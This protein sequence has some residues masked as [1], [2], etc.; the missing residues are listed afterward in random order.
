[1]PSPPTPKDGASMEVLVS[2]T[3]TRMLIDTGTG[4]VK[5][6]MSSGPLYYDYSEPFEHILEIFP[7]PEGNEVL[8]EVLTGITNHAKKLLPYGPVAN[9]PR[10]GRVKLSAEV[11][12]AILPDIAELPASPVPRRITRDLILEGLEPSST[13]EDV[14]ESNKSPYSGKDPESGHSDSLPG[15]T[16]S[17]N[18]ELAAASLNPE[19]RNNQRH[20][21]LSQTGSSVLDSSTLNFAVRYSIPM[22]TTA[23]FGTDLARETASPASLGRSTEDGMSELLAGYQHT[24]SKQEPD[25]LQQVEGTVNKETEFEGYHEK[26]S[27]HT[28]RSSDERSFKSCTVRANPV[29]EPTSPK[30]DQDA[31]SF[32]SATD[33]LPEQEPS[34]KASNA[35]SINSQTAASPDRAASMPLSRPPS[36]KLVK[37][38]PNLVRT[39]S[40]MP[41]SSPPPAVLRKQPPSS[42]RESSLSAV[43]SKM[44]GSSRPSMA[45]G[46][47]SISGSS[48]NLGVMQ[49]PPVPPR[50]SSSSKEA[51]RF[52]GVAS[53]LAGMPARFTKGRKSTKDAR[54]AKLDAG[55]QSMSELTHDTSEFSSV[56]SSSQFPTEVIKVPEKVMSK[57][58]LVHEEQ[59]V[60]SISSKDFGVS[61]VGSV[62]VPPLSNRHDPSSPAPVANEPSSVY[63]PQD[64]SMQDRGQT[65]PIRV[66]TSPDR[67]RRDSQ[68]TTHLVWPGARR[69]L[70]MPSASASEPRL[71]LPSVQEDTTTDLRLSAYRYPGPSRYLPDLKEESHE[72]SSLNTSASNLKN[73]HFRFPHGGPPGVRTSVEDA[74]RLSRSSSTGSPRRSVRSSALGQTHGLPSMRFSKMNL[75]EKLNEELGLRYPRSV[76]IE[77]QVFQGG[78]APPPGLKSEAREKYRSLFAELDDEL[79]KVEGSAEP[80]AMLDLNT[81]KRAYSPEKLM[82]EI[83][84]LSIPSVGGLTQRISELVPSLKEYYKLGEQGEFVEE[85]LIM[86]HAMEDIH[87]VGGPAQKRSSA[88]LRP[89]AGSPNM[90]VIDD[91]L[92]EE[93]TNPD[94]GTASSGRQGDGGVECGHSE[95]GSH[96]KGK[97]EN[98]AQAQVLLQAPLTEI[99]TPPPAFLRPRSH[100][101]GQQQIRSSVESGL[102]SSRSLRSFTPTATDTRPWNSDR[103]YPWATTTIP[104]IDI[105]LP[106]PTAVKDSPR[107]GPSHLRNRLSNTS[108]STS[109]STADTAT[110]SPFGTA[111]GSNAHARQH[112]FS[113]FGRTGDQPHAAGERYPT[114]ALT[115]PTAIFRDHSSSLDTCDDEDFTVAPKSRLGLKKRFSSARSAALDNSTR[116]GRSKSNPLELASPESTKQSTTSKP[117]D[118]TGEA[119]VITANHRH[120]FRDAGGMPIST[121]HRSKIINHLKK[122]WHKGGELIRK[123]SGRKQEDTSTK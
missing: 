11:Q 28:G 72:D 40:E 64:F 10:P 89:M 111:S 73:S 53:F 61:K 4:V 62:G 2:P 122:W 81:L 123:I 59:I 8:N 16:N 102:S 32:K 94:K 52:Q 105:S 74:V 86:E 77:L 98:V 118:R 13:E 76:E 48:S 83:D 63:S 27:H 91:A 78:G 57:P 36:A 19:E 38:N 110:A 116:V 88:R 66:P 69:S 46:S 71:S 107:P 37:A 21:I 9:R 17:M 15:G 104:S 103:N 97:Q 96:A 68:T 117:Q 115:P 90:V 47:M 99:T 29:S 80:T 85:E 25:V 23:G 49:P 39:V 108:T 31:K 119:Q 112:R 84:Q 7:E 75:I 44:R 67:N 5:E 41:I 18:Q 82:S 114:S 56:A 43:P 120:T 79:K 22:A 30:S 1:M 50:E 109:F 70:T 100:T 93:L 6:D 58:Q 26:R 92:Y 51:Q 55:D 33:I 35:C 95:A 42:T 87:E 106:S 34:A 65:S 121:Y 3:G 54:N 101:A 24:D 113:A 14:E 12:R 60:L 20:S 45:Q